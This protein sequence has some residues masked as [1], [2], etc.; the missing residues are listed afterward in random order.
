[1]NHFLS[2]NTKA[3]KLL[4][5]IVQ[6]VIGV[7]IANIDIIFASF[8][9]PIEAKTMIVP[10]VMAVLSPVMASLGTTETYDADTIDN[11]TNN[12]GE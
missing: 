9:I 8:T 3:M 11:L 10:L 7:L 12:K 6:G 4:R 2:S 5:T 1:M